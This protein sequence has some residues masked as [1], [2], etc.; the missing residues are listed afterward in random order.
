[1]LDETQVKIQQ[2]RQKIKMFFGSPI[3]VVEMVNQW[4]EKNAVH[5]VEQQMQVLEQQIIVSVIYISNVKPAASTQTLPP[6]KGQQPLINMEAIRA[7]Y[8]QT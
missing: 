6:T 8:E 4:V 7:A 1:M 3:Q 5:I 2:Q